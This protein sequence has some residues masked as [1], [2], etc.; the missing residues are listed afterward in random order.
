MTG[1][2]IRIKKKKKVYFFLGKKWHS[3]VGI[4]K[5]EDFMEK[6]QTSSYLGG[7]GL[8]VPPSWIHHIMLVIAS[9]GERD[10]QN[11]MWE[12]HACV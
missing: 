6:P 12:L 4:T 10:Y 11:N 2:K 7:G 1:R 9:I 3:V 8:W 5:V